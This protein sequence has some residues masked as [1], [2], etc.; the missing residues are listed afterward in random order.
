MIALAAALVVVATPVC[1]VDRAAMLALP[2]HVFDQTDGQGWRTLAARGCDAVATDLIAAYRAAH[3]N[4]RYR[5]IMAWHEGQMRANAG[6]DARARP[7]F[8]QARHIGD[9]FGWNDYVDA[10]IAFI[11]RDRHALLAARTRLA[12]TPRPETHAWFDPDGHPIPGPVLAP[13]QAWPDN[14]PVVDALVRC[15]KRSY[16]AAYATAECYSR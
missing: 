10:T 12:A 3:P 6:D 7:L 14:L 1:G 16:K 11:D 13:G 9:Q 5:A 2:R 4:D 15:F 8:M